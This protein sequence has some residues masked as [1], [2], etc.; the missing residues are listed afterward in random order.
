MEE[1]I[2]LRDVENLDENEKKRVKEILVKA[3]EKFQRKLKTMKLVEI[4]FKLYKKKGKRKKYSVN[5]RVVSAEGVFEGSYA[6][7]DAIKT[8]HEVIEKVNNEI[9]KRV[10]KD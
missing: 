3:Y 8:T 9:K 6:D 10:K 2:L 5:L 1:K 4:H 7:W